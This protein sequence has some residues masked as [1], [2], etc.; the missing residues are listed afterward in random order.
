MPPATYVGWKQPHSGAA[1]IPGM[2]SIRVSPRRSVEEPAGCW[3]ATLRMAG[4]RLLAATL[5]VVKMAPIRPRRRG[6]NQGKYPFF[7]TTCVAELHGGKCLDFQRA[8]PLAA[9]GEKDGVPA[10]GALRN[11]Q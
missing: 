4:S 1:S 7:I 5:R 8:L 9:A 6:P 10:R 11:C 2:L 3:L